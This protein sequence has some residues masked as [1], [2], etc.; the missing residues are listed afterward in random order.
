MWDLVWKSEKKIPFGREHD[1]NVCSWRFND[2]NV[3]VEVGWNNL[4][5]I[6]EEKYLAFKVNNLDW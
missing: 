6:K 3:V 1:D 5:S 4:H 2:F